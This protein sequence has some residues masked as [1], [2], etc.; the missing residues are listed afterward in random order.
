MNEKEKGTKLINRRES[1]K[2]E[3][4]LM[5]LLLLATRASEV[6][7][8]HIQMANY[9]GRHTHSHTQAPLLCQCTQIHLAMAT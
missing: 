1:K 5:L 8:A 4:L 3:G 7:R 2:K 9:S 6:V